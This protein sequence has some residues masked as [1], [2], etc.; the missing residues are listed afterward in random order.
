MEPDVFVGPS[1]LY[2]LFILKLVL[3]HV[4]NELRVGETY[5][6]E[7]HFLFDVL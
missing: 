5:E 7:D 4:N 6:E 3:A 2:E 1:I